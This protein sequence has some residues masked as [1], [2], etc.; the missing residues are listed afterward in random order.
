MDDWRWRRPAASDFSGTGG[1]TSPGEGMAEGEGRVPKVAI[2]RI[3]GNP[4]NL[5]NLRMLFFLVGAKR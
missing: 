1:C 3:C 2:H 4:F 5:R